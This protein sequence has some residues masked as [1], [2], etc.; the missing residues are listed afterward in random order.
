[1]L[2]SSKDRVDI[3]KGFIGSYP[4]CF[5]DVTLDQLPDFLNLLA[6]MQGNEQEL[7]RFR[8]YGV[9]R[10][11]DDF[12]AHYDW[13]QKRFYQDKPVEAGLFDLNRYYY[14]AL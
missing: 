9:N 1:V 8:T 7:Q 14:K 11:E 12:W 4:N 6:N 10:A 2:D 5:F 3:L 13:F